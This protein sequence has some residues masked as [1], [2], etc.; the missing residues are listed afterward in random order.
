MRQKAVL[1]ARNPVSHRPG[2]N[3]CI[4]AL[5]LVATCRH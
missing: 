2:N 4:R 3:C 5:R 1:S